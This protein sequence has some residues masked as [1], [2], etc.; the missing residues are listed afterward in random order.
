M[1]NAPTILLLGLVL[2]AVLAACGGGA[3]SPS[4]AAPSVAAPSVAAPSAAPSEAASEAPSAAASAAASEAAAA[5]VALAESSLGQILVDAEGLT[6]Y[7]FVPDEETG[8]PTCYDDCATAW[9]A[10]LAEGTP[11]AGEGLDA[12]LLSTATRTDGGTQVKY[13]TWPLYYFSGDA[14]A[15]ETN[16]QGLNEV[17]YVV[18][19]DGNPI[20]R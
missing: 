18:G 16:G 1:R 15:G 17:W 11:T 7:M 9:P 2:S 14:A 10:L 20:G 19:A 3:A 12:S 6:L 5:T 8:E 13:G 4:A